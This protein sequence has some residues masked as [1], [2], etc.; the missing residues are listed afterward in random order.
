MSLPINISMLMSNIL[1]YDCGCFQ[2]LEVLLCNQVGFDV[3]Y[4]I[5]YHV[6]ISLVGVMLYRRGY[7]LCV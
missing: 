1:I 4:V 6:V 3:Y 7:D 2:S 5:L